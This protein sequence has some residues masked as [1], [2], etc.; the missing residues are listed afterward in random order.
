MYR[1]AIY[2]IHELQ[3][4]IKL[5]VLKLYFALFPVPKWSVTDFERIA[6]QLK[7]EWKYRLCNLGDKPN[8]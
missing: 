1:K 5:I 6:T 3:T 2:M 8:R 4:P 7:Y